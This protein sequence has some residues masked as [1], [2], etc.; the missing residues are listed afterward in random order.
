MKARWDCS[1]RIASFDASTWIVLAAAR[2]ATEIVFANVDNPST[3]KWPLPI[4]KERLRSIVFPLPALLGLESSFDDT[5]GEEMEFETDPLELINWVRA[6]NSF[7][8]YRSVLPPGK[9]HYTVTLRRDWR[10]PVFNSNEIAWRSFAEEIGALVI[11]D[12]DVNPIHLHERFALYAGAEQNFGTVTGP[13]HLITLSDHPAMIF[14]ANILAEAFIKRGIEFGENYP[15]ALA[16]QQLIWAN[17]KLKALRHHYNEWRESN[18]PRD[19]F[20]SLG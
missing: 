16:N 2:G 4:V 15:W 6:G 7:P 18:E 1:Q 8:R 5:V 3:K 10:V 13:M 11:E 17:D 20:D 14:K 9:H 19:D 12:Y